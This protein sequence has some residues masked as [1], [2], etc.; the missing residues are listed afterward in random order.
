M[1]VLD[2][3]SSSAPEGMEAYQDGG[4]ARQVLGHSMD[5]ASCSLQHTDTV[6]GVQGEAC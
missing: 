6:R 2:P 1:Y 5:S 4:L 3:P